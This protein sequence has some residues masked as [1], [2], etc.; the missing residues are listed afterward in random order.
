MALDEYV[1]SGFVCD[2]QLRVR[3]KHGYERALAR[4]RDGEVVVT[5]AHRRA[6]RSLQANRYYFG[7]VLKL[8]SDHTGYT[9]LELHEYFKRRFLGKAILICDANGVVMD[10]DRVG[11]TTTRLNKVEFYEYIESI[12][13]VGAEMGV[14]TPDPDPHYREKSVEAA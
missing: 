7:A 10:E 6:T 5:I 9:V 2:G 3:N 11:L 14:V 13:R 12:R 4:M 1:T 8:L